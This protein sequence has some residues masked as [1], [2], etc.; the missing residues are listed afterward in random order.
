MTND[1][2]GEG[3]AL[4]WLIQGG[5]GIAVS[6]WPLARSVS[7]AGQ[8]GVVSGTA[9]E[10]VFVR[11]LQDHGVDDGLR[12][13]LEK[14][15]DQ[16]IVEAVLARYTKPRRPG[17]K[18]PYRAVPMLTHRTVHATQDLLVLASYAE[19]AQAKA[20]HDGLV[21]INLLTKVQIPTVPTLFGAMLAGVDYVVMGAGIPVHIPGVLD[22]LSRGSL[23]EMALEVVGEAPKEL[24]PV[25][26]FD[27]AR[28]AAD[29]PLHRPEFL[30]I[31]SSHVLA[32][33]L[34]KRSSGA[35][36]GF[37]VEG[38][39]AGG[40][41]APPRGPLVLDEAGEPIYGERDQVDFAA[42]RKIGLP[43]WIAGGIT[44][45]L[46]VRQALELGAVGV[47]VGT[48]F[49]YCQESGMED[50]LR[51]RV[52]DQVRHGGVRVKT[53]VRASSTG[54]PFKVAKVPDTLSEEK[55]YDERPRIC[56][57]GYLR[58]AYIKSDGAVGYR[59]PSEP[60]TQFV[61]KG[62]DLEETGERTCLCNALMSAAGF[63]QTRQHGYQEPP[64]VTSGDSINEIAPLLTDR[65][66]YSAVDVI[67][68]LQV[69]PRDA[70]SFEAQPG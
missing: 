36:N 66:D 16:S 27:P 43:F 45:S 10:T 70:R 3:R 8:L 38:P 39:T 47:Q 2:V 44:S 18:T 68:Y 4:P 46:Q 12:A 52:M 54:Y 64:I 50:G 1:S 51:R 57:L 29:F 19:V 32:N 67:E 14:F 42:M 69:D 9:I 23:V 24:V 34:V 6:H 28:F 33:A 53:S 55:V 31:V 62:G 26:R 37:V 30:G 49:A 48:L 17:S 61:K 56:D 11:R 7:L 13:V 63:P 41:N 58:D 59:C 65:E 20:G 5:M 21:G 25:L 40:H 22:Q 15:P 60:V 35:V